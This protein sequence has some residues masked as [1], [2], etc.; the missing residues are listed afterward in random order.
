MIRWATVVDPTATSTL[1][2]GWL[3]VALLC[4]HGAVHLLETLVMTCR[5]PPLK[6]LGP[7]TTWLVCFCACSTQCLAA[8][9][10]R[11]TAAAHGGSE[12]TALVELRCARS[13]V[14]YKVRLFIIKRLD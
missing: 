8:E 4:G 11:A 10:E 5:L 2:S 14:T 9:H 13:H 7:M 12:K 6:P 1:S 3:H